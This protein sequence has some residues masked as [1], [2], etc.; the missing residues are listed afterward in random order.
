MRPSTSLRIR[1]EPELSRENRRDQYL[2]SASDP[3]ATATFGRRYV[4][5]EIEQREIS[6]DT[7][8]EWTLSPTLS[9]Q[10]FAQPF[11]SEGRYTSFAE[12]RAP[13]TYA[14]DVYGRDGGTVTRDRAQSLVQVDPDGAGAAPSFAFEEP[15]FTVRS[16]RG[17]AVLRWEYRPG[18]AL[19]VVWQQR[20]NAELGTSDLAL[21][22][23]ARRIFGDPVENVLLVKATYWLTR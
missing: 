19:F 3:L 2:T 1:L 17:N 13:R 20:R 8:V 11:V 15:D 18:S 9:F 14:F 5:G 16:L 4:F 23:D 6:L 10:L 22:G 12:L 21:G 7:R